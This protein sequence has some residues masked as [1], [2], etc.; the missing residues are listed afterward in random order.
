[1]LVRISG[2]DVGAIG[3]PFQKLILEDFDSDH[4]QYSAPHKLSPT[5]THRLPAV[6]R[7]FR[8]SSFN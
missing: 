7:V 2:V 6:V 3:Q 8:F 5:H 1:M 4:F